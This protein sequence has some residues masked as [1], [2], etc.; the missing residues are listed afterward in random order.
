MEF[1]KFLNAVRKKCG[2]KRPNV[3]CSSSGLKTEGFSIMIRLRNALESGNRR[4]LDKAPCINT[5]L[6]I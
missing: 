5:S 4:P 1:R 6:Y 3:L 2:K